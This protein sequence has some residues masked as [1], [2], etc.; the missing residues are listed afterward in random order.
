MATTAAP[1]AAVHALR[2]AMGLGDLVLFS[3]VAVLNL[4]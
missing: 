3:I 2:R 1:G 4:R